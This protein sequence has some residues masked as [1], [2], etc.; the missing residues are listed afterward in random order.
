MWLPS[1]VAVLTYVVM[2]V[3]SRYPRLFNY[4]FPV[5]EEQR[6]RLQPVAVQMHSWLQTEIM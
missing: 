4:P 5:T 1:R 3:S 6:T 2:T